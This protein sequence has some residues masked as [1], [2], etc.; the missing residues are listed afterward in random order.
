MNYRKGISKDIEE[1]AKT[2]VPVLRDGGVI[3]ASVF[4]SFTRGDVQADS[5]L[6]LLVRYKE[7]VRTN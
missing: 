3:E 2:I 4:G 7:T 6:D 5:D 1:L